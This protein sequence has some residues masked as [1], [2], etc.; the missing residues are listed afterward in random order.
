MFD[1]STSWLFWIYGN[2]DDDDDDEHVTF[3]LLPCLPYG[4][5]TKCMNLQC[6][7]PGTRK[8]VSF[9]TSEISE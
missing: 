5:C 3:V 7:L 9:T 1:F 6:T 8:R 2:K 4:C